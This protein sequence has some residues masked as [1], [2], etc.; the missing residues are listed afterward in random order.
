MVSWDVP[1]SHANGARYDSVML[2]PIFDF[3]K[4]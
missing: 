2:I 1:N 3:N 4:C